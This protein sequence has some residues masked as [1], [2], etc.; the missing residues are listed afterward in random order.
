M[1]DKTVK[2]TLSG[3]AV[4]LINL[5]QGIVKIECQGRIFKTSYSVFSNLYRAL[6]QVSGFCKNFNS[7]SGPSYKYYLECTGATAELNK[8]IL[9]IIADVGVMKSP[10]KDNLRL[11]K[12]PY[13]FDLPIDVVYKVIDVFGGDCE[14]KEDLLIIPNLDIPV[15]PY[16]NYKNDYYIYKKYINKNRFEI[17]KGVK[18]TVAIASDLSKLIK[19]STKEIIIPQNSNLLYFN[20]MTTIS[21]T[22]YLHIVL[23]DSVCF[24]PAISKEPLLLKEVS[25]DKALKTQVTIESETDNDSIKEKSEDLKTYNLLV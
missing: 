25:L 16:K 12:R 23:K 9:A 21:E 20:G 18:S 13:Y 24:C 6:V 5:Q 15:L 14:D 8:D 1:T 11:Y 22:D 10:K 17:I 19:N 3:C 4:E 2:F 7:E